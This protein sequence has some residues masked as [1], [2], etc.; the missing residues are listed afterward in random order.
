MP[1]YIRVSYCNWQRL[2]FPSI[3]EALEPVELAQGKQTVFV[4]LSHNPRG[5]MAVFKSSHQR[6]WL[7][8]PNKRYST[9]VTYS[10]NSSFTR[11]LLCDSQQWTSKLRSHTGL[12]ACHGSSMPSHV[13]THLTLASVC[14]AGS[15]G[16]SADNSEFASGSVTR[17]Y[18]SGT[19]GNT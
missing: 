19:F 10:S 9:T 13:D 12:A 11:R 7:Q 16:N 15:K 14:L 8:D 1:D 6:L 17:S 2:G 5:W 18:N 3:Q 4:F